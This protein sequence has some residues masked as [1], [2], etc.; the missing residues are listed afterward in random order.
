MF[1]HF[2]ERVA[3]GRSIRSEATRLISTPDAPAHAVPEAGA[4]TADRDPVAHAFREAVSL[5]VC[6]ELGDRE[7]VRTRMFAFPWSGWLDIS[8]D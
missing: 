2:S 8:T 6:R 5:R 3:Y 4:D 1:P 7:R